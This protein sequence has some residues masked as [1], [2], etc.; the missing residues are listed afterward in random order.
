MSELKLQFCVENE[1]EMVSLGERVAKALSHPLVITLAGDL[2]AGKTTLARGILNQL[3]HSGH[4]KSP[5]FSIVE[6]YE[7][8]SLRVSHFDMYRVKDTEELNFFGFHEYFDIS[9]L[10]LIEWPERIATVD[11]CVDLEINF[12]IVGKARNLNFNPMS[13]SGHSTLNKLVQ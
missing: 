5:T 11:L 2:G 10:I 8:N 7:I 3:G 6:T 13:E 4:V 1:F 12:T 9:D